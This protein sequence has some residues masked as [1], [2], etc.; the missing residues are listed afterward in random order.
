MPPATEPPAKYAIREA[1]AI[2]IHSPVDQLAYCSIATPSVQALCMADL[3]AAAAR[4][5]EVGITGILMWEGRLMIHWLEGPGYALDAFWS[6]TES[7]P[8]QHCLV[9]LLRKRS[10]AQRLFTTWTMQP[11]SRNEMMAIVREAKEQASRSG[12][13]QALQWQHA[14][15]T[16]SILL[17]SELTALY[18]QAAVAQKPHQPHQPHQPRERVA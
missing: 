17:D 5:D 6:H 15:S 12:D 9:P 13:P 14:I 10:A 16:L 18:A 7:D 2:G 1:Q 4:G 11:T 3:V 8:R